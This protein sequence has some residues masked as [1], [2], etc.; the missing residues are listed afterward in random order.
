MSQNIKDDKLTWNPREQP[1]QLEPVA[2][3]NTTAELIPGMVKESSGWDVYN[4]EA[5]K[6]DTELVNDWRASLNSLLLFAAIFAAVLT[7]FIIES[8]KM[9]E[10]DPNAVMM[11]VM[12]RFTNNAA[13]GTHIPY[14]PSDF[15]APLHAVTV[16]C[17]FFASLSTSLVAALASVVALQWVADYDAAITRGGSSP[18]DRAK[19]RQF[20]YT[21]VI[22]W[23]M[24]EIIAALPLLL[25]FSVILFFAGLIL[26]MR[27]LHYTVG[28]VVAG[29]A[30][31]AGLFYVPMDLLLRSSHLTLVVSLCGRSASPNNLSMAEQ[32]APR[33]SSCP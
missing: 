7:A 6:V 11:D 24:G 15:E 2:G 10:Q 33:P 28:L 23:K 18:E 27:I 8:K 4:N 1:P 14:I 20:R 17:L 32:V 13:N 30:G 19:R 22:S 31:L 21:G 29:G 16:N 25:Y 26:W 5:K 3:I 12:I 9:L